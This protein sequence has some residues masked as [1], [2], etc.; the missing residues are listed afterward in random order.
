M[1]SRLQLNAEQRKQLEVLDFSRPVPVPGRRNLTLRVMSIVL[2]ANDLARRDIPVCAA[3]VRAGLVALGYCT[4]DTGNQALGDVLGSWGLDLPRRKR[5][6]LLG[7]EPRMVTVYDVPAGGVSR[8]DLETKYS[9]PKDWD[10]TRYAPAD[11]GG[12]DQGKNPPL[13]AT[14]PEDEDEISRLLRDLSQDD[15]PCPELQ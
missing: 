5:K 14:E 1:E 13:A 7:G 2:V 8:T 3:T 10:W 12:H 11:D 15:E 6:V 4:E 9:T